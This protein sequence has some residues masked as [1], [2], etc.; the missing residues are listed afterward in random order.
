[1]LGTFQ[2]LREDQQW[3]N[4]PLSDEEI[5]RRARIETGISFAEMVARAEQGQ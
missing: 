5:A 3:R 4:P 2:P 1:V